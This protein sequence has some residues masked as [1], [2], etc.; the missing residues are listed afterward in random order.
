MSYG[1]IGGLIGALIGLG[2]FIAIR[3]LADRIEASRPDEAGRRTGNLM[4]TV[5]WLDLVVFTI[6]GYVAGILLFA[7][8]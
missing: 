3:K 5:A 6:G 4:R 1:L 2:G 7:G 8:E